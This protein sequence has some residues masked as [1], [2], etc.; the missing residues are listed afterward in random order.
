MAKIAIDAG[1]GGYDSGATYNGRNEK[2]DNLEIALAVGELLEQNGQEVIYTRMTDVYDSPVKKA[3]IANEQDADLFVSIHR[4]SSP[5]PNTYSGVETLVYDDTGLK[6]DIAKSINEELE[7]VGYNNLG[8]EERKDL[9]V[10]RKT[11]MPAL[12]VEVGFINTEADNTLLDSKFDETVNAIADG[13]LSELEK[14]QD[15]SVNLMRDEE[16]GPAI[17]DD[18]CDEAHKHRIQVGLYK[19]YDNA[20]KVAGELEALGFPVEMRSSGGYYAVQAGPVVT[21]TEVIELENQLQMLG[22][23]TLPIC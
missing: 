23:E 18:D 12:L 14:V 5:S 19:S 16:P 7:A 2:D 6:A 22:Y 21:P 1:H 13:I 3:Q 17:T 4:N 20:L 8:I 10:L 9:A 11:E 15:N